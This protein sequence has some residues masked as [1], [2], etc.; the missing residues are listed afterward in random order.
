MRLYTRRI[1][2][3]QNKN[4]TKK[5]VKVLVGKTVGRKN[6]ASTDSISEARTALV[7]VIS[8][9]AIMFECG[10]EV[11]WIFTSQ[12]CCSYVTTIV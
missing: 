12:L 3:L 11:L 9:L 6:Y 5:E 1:D 2:R 7:A 4:A 8:I 10:S